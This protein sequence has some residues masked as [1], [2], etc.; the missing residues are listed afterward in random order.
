M[1]EMKTTTEGK[2]N[3]SVCTN[4]LQKSAEI[5]TEASHTYIA[6]LVQDIPKTRI[7]EKSTGKRPLSDWFSFM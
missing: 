2:Y 7:Y 6:E 1:M 4:N 5:K 3:E